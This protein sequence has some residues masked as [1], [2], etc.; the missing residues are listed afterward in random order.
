MSISFTTLMTAVSVA[1][2]LPACVTRIPAQQGQAKLRAGPR[3]FNHPGPVIIVDKVDGK[4]NV[5]DKRD[6]SS[7]LSPGPHEIELKTFAGSGQ[8][9]GELVLLLAK[10][11]APPPPPP[12]QTVH[13]FVAVS[14]HDYLYRWALNKNK[15]GESIWIE[16]YNLGG[17]VVSG[18]RPLGAPE[19]SDPFKK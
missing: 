1:I 6:Y 19:M 7:I 4:P 18:V 15:P 16:D 10:A 2:L 3:N 11:F 8:Q 14:G 5:I 13:R 17:Q 9:P 12:P